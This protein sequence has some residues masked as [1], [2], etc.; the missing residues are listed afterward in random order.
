MRDET[1]GSRDGGTSAHRP[2][3]TEVIS[4]VCKAAEAER[5]TVRDVLG[6]VG[7]ASFAPLLLVPALAVTSP[8]SGI[9]L[10][11]SLMG[12]TIFIISMQMLFRRKHIWL[13]DWVLRRQ[14]KGKTVQK[15]FRSLRSVARWLD[16]R[17]NER[18]SVLVRRPMIF[19]VQLVCALSGAAMPLFEI[20]PFTSSILGAGVAILALGMMAR[21]GLVVLFGLTPYF[22]AGYLIATGVA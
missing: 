16:R 10:F 14:V 11:S 6:T 15:A 13:P 22:L 8:L 21:D 3:L 1:V 12:L 18:L 4:Q 5:I 19:L 17:T 7:G 9:P 20:V 2:D